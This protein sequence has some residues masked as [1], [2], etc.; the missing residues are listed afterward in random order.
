MSIAMEREVAVLQMVRVFVIAGV[1][2]MLIMLPVWGV[3]A[4]PAVVG[5]IIGRYNRG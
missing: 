5:P 1:L 4:K 3:G 2:I